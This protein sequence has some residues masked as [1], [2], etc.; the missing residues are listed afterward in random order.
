MNGGIMPRGTRQLLLPASPLFIWTSLVIAL[1]A[2]I[3]QNLLFWGRAGWAPDL[4]A[5]VLVFWNIHQPQRVGVGVA[6]LFGLAMDVHQSALLG[7]H[8][9][10]YTL[11]SFTALAIHRRILWFKTP[12]QALQLLP[13][14]VGAHLLEFALRYFFGGILPSWHFFIAPFLESTLWPLVAVLLLLPQ[15]RSPDPDDNRPL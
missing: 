6:F 3:A 11:L 2:N 8:A 15:R 1:V 10:V 4:L 7:Q 12:A 5:I 9:L 14:F 13:L